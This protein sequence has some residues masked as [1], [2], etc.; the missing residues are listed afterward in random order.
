[1]GSCELF[2]PKI[3][4]KDSQTLFQKS[5]SDAGKPGETTFGKINPKKA[6]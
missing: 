6:D 4:K 1:V 2:A 5:D 3:E